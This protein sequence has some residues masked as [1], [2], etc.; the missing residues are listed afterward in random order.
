M[1]EIDKLVK[2]LEDAR[3]W[4]SYERERKSRDQAKRDIKAVEI[5]DS[6]IKIK[7][8]EIK[9]IKQAIRDLNSN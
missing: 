1:E 2:R 7:E 9:E 5:A 3:H 6:N 4:I 8:Q